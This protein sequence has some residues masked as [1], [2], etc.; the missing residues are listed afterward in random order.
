[1]PK[2]K[3]KGRT[4]GHTTNP[5]FPPRDK[6]KQGKGKGKPL[7]L[8]SRKP[9]FTGTCIHCGIIGHMARDCYKRQNETPSTVKQNT[10]SFTEEL[11]TSLTLTQKPEL[12]QFQ[13]FPTFMKRKLEGSST[14]DDS[15]EEKSNN[16][17]LPPEQESMLTNTCQ[18]TD[19]WEAAIAMKPEAAQSWG[20]RNNPNQEEANSDWGDTPAIQP[21]TNYSPD[22]NPHRSGICQYCDTPIGS[23]KMNGPL[24]C[25]SCRLLLIE[26]EEHNK[27]QQQY[28]DT[29]QVKED[30]RQ[31]RYQAQIAGTTE[32][33]ESQQLG[34]KDEDTRWGENDEDQPPLILLPEETSPPTNNTT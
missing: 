3:G 22:R 2:G 25:H 18:A 7:A 20:L 34:E 19:K 17:H 24:T 23:K 16:A 1:M 30:Q 15:D 21:T 8:G 29:R 26:D 10:V 27:E 6:G 9:K 11:P 14:N 13:Q 12:I 33:S 28:D 32:D 31:A 5:W 4:K